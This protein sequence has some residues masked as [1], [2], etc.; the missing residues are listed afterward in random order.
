MTQVTKINYR[1]ELHRI[2]SFNSWPIRNVVQFANSGFYYIRKPDWVQCFACQTILNNW[3]NHDDVY[4]EHVKFAPGCP[5]VRD[6]PCGNVPLY[7]NETTI[8]EM[9]LTK[10]QPHLSLN[11]SINVDHVAYPNLANLQARKRTYFNWP[12]NCVHLVD[13][14]IDAGLF[15]SPTND[16]LTC[17]MCGVVIQYWRM[18]SNTT[19]H[20]SWVQHARFSPHCLY[21]IHKKGL[22]YIHS[23]QS[24]GVHHLVSKKRTGN[25]NMNNKFLFFFSE[26]H[27]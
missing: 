24:Q 25:N 2:M 6:T 11:G 1:V 12:A 9:L 13:T 27:D 15:Y 5:M 22:K 19:T 26:T 17:F 16:R 20:Q 4:A 3:E 23:L 18:T 21:L 7:K 10:L 8:P 14:F